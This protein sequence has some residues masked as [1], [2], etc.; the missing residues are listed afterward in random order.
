MTAEVGYQIGERD[1]VLHARSPL[2]SVLGCEGN[3][4]EI[5]ET[6]AMKLAEAALYACGGSGADRSGSDGDYNP[7]NAVDTR[8]NRH[9]VREDRQHAANK[10]RCSQSSTTSREPMHP[11]ATLFGDARARSYRRGCGGRRWRI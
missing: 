10:F 3:E 2:L 11:H 4:V 8:L 1:L 7:E 5:R 9:D 6:L